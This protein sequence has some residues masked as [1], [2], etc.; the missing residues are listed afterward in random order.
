MLLPFGGVGIPKPRQ[1]RS[2]TPAYGAGSSPIQLARL[3]VPISR[4][5]PARLA[6]NCGGATEVRMSGGVWAVISGHED[7]SK[8]T[9]SLA[10]APLASRAGRGE[11]TPQTSMERAS[12]DTA[13]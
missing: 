9:T 7:V 11:G 13:R 8:P 12:Y 3:P 6:C 5:W 10:Q 1:G 4:F 2:K